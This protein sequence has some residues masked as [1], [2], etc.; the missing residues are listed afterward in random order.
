MP[1]YAFG[2][3]TLFAT[4]KQDANGNAI[5]NP[6]P[7][8][9]G[10]LQDVSLDISF[11]LK[12]LYG[13]NQFP[14]AIGRGKGKVSGKADFAQINGL[15]LN[16][17]V[18]GQTMTAGIVGDV[19]DTTGTAI[20]ATPYTITPSPPN[21]GTWSSDLGVVDATGLPMIHVAS[22][23]T[24]GQYSVS[25]GVYTFAAADTTKVVFINYQYTATSTSAQKST[26]QNVLMGYAPTFQADLF[27]AYGGKQMII[28]LPACISTK[29]SLATKL[30]DFMLPS[31]DFEAFADA[32]GNV[33]TYSVTDR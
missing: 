26:V 28:S 23:P 20:P 11:D 33:L 22:A 27:G 9:F 17:L 10:A 1:Q 14:L 3:G 4:P 12:T 13:Q 29:L 31:F 5:A 30:D 16:S 2:A 6:T 7:I 18:F 19:V 24:T 32:S 21:S 8:R 25:A 15:A